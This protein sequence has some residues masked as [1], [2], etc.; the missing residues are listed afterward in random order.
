VAEGVETSDQVAFLREKGCPE[1]QGYYFSRPMPAD[2]FARF[3]AGDLPATALAT[4]GRGGRL[5]TLGSLL[6]THT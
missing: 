6:Q 2:Q 5:D 1:A 4:N 3:F